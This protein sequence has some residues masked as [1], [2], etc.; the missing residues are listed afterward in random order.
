ML[1]DISIIKDNKKDHL[2]LIST[3]IK[4]LTKPEPHQEILVI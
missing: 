1:V 4:M 2:T 3:D